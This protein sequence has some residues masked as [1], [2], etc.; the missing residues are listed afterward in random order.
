M[1]N[2]SSLNT[3]IHGVSILF[4]EYIFT[5]IKG[6]SMS[7]TGLWRSSSFT[8]PLLTSGLH[9]IILTPKSLVPRLKKKDGWR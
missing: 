8:P 1:Y 6:N 7:M 5:G 3:R 2:V 9:V 4:L